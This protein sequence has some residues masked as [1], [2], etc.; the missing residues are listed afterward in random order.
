MQS[1]WD[2]VDLQVVQTAIKQSF[3]D[4]GTPAE[5][6]DVLGVDFLEWAL[7]SDGYVPPAGN[8]PFGK[9]YVFGCMGLLD[10]KVVAHRQCQAPARKPEYSFEIISQGPL[11]LGARS[12]I[13]E[14]VE[15]GLYGLPDKYWADFDTLHPPTGKPVKMQELAGYYAILYRM[16]I[17]AS[18]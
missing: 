18:P 16:R 12:A 9:P 7:D 4:L 17:H 8:S 3:K 2:V 10:Q 13:M 14:V 6:V 11:T 1:N 15:G 5:A